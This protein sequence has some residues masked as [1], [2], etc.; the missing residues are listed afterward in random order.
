[1]VKVP[2]IASGGMGTF[3]HFEEVVNKTGVSA[4]AIASMLHYD[5]ISI[6]EIRKLSRSRGIEVRRDEE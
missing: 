6:S 5:M 3:Q 1:M 4:V 2:V